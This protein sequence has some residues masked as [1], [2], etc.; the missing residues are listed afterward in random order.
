M[1]IFKKITQFL[2]QGNTLYVSR[3]RRMV[4]FKVGWKGREHS[5]F[6]E[7]DK[8]SRREI[9]ACIITCYLAILI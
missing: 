9:A 3:A 6:R 1:S 4:H 7:A 2:K 5:D 8:W